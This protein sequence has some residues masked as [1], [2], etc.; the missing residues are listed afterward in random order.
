MPL[1]EDVSTAK[2]KFKDE[3]HY[4]SSTGFLIMGEHK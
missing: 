3:T 1:A 2:G 4:S